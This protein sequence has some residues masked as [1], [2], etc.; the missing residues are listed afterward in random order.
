MWSG[1]CQTRTH[2]GG[3]GA[4]R[5][6]YW[7]LEATQ[8]SK[9]LALGAT[10]PEIIEDNLRLIRLKSVYGS[11]NLVTARPKNP[12]SCRGDAPKV[13]QTQCGVRLNSE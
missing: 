6:I 7:M 5:Y 12:D 3:K 11:L 8:V 9:L 2:V 1:R 4:K 13:G 10:R